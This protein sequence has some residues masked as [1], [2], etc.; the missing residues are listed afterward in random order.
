M[1]NEKLEVVR[2][3]GNVF[4]DLRHT[5]AAAEQI[6]GKFWPLESSR[7]SIRNI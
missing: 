4:L 1:K 2:G 3:S 6:Q 7:C 5:N